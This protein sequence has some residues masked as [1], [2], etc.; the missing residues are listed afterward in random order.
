M[1]AE[2]VQSEQ[3]R[4]CFEHA[5]VGIG[6]LNLDLEFLQSNPFLG[7]MLSAPARSLVGA[8]LGE[9][10]E[11]QTSPESGREILRICSKT[12]QTGKPH[13][14]HG[15]PANTDANGFPRFADWEIRRIEDAHHSPVGLLVT[16]SDVTRQKYVEEKVRLLA[17]VLETTPDWVA[18]LSPVGD[19]L[20]LNRSAKLALGLT[21][22]APIHTLRYWDLHPEWAAKLL[23]SEGFPVALREGIWE[24]ETAFMSAEHGDIPV[25]QVLCSHANPAGE[26]EFVSSILRDITEAHQFQEQ[27]A[28]AQETLEQRVEERTAALAE[29]SELIRNRVHQ[30]AAV[31]ELGELALSGTD[32]PQLLQ[33]SVRSIVEFLG[34][35]FCSVRELSQEGDYLELRACIGGPQVLAQ[36]ALPSGTG[37]PS[38]FALKSGAPVIFEDLQ[39][40]HRFSINQWLRESGCASGVAVPI[41]IKEKPFGALSVFSV[42]P[43]TFSGN[44]THFLQS[45]ANIIAAAVERQQAE[46]GIQKALNQAETANRAKNAFLSRMSHELRT[47]LNAVL[48]FTQLL[49]LEDPT[50]SQLESLDHVSRA[51]QHLLSLINEVLDIS[52]IEAGRV[53]LTI[54]S[55]ELNDFLHNCIEL[56]RPL[57]ARTT[58]GLQFVSNSKPTHVRADRQRLKQVVLN[59]LSNAIKYN[60]EGG[61]VLVSLRCGLENARFEVR[62]TGPGIPEQK[63]ALLF[64]SFERLGAEHGGVEGTGIGLALCKGFVE[65][66]GGTI[67]LED[68]DGGG[69][70][71]WAQLPLAASPSD[72]PQLRIGRMPDILPHASK[73]DAPARLLCIE[74]HDFDLQLLERLLK[75]HP[76]YSLLS[77]MQGRIGLELAREHRPDLI[78]VDLDLPDLSASDFLSRL[79]SETALRETPLIL[80]SADQEDASLEILAQRHAATLMHKPYTPSELLERIQSTLQHPASP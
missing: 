2:Q 55:V 30:Q 77:A 69:C 13:T 73:L 63:R 11:E 48:G 3:L 44:D 79:R 18:V 42:Q 57:A 49:K 80:L 50:P 65:A 5:P 23:Q 39:N 41:S 8:S 68:P 12:I 7:K 40:E 52:H 24:G 51:G 70:V 74:G 61:Q 15:W 54:Q 66:M 67:G 17:S 34:V 62:D 36:R 19:V 16:V 22:A 58:V 59:F 43:R 71:F 46:A 33:E 32:I 4:L 47:P 29:A 53:A 78:L 20:Y 38:G 27:L 56:M 14:L 60:N 26:V 76:N 6:F 37:S 75:N 1:R 35:D 10:L 9:V 31:A 45:V 28:R 21:D 64:K 72:Q 25:S